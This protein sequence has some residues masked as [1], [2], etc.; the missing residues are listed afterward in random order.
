M[1]RTRRYSP[2]HWLSM[3]L[4]AA[5]MCLV[6]TGTSL[7]MGVSGVGGRVGFTDPDAVDPTVTFGLHAELEQPGSRLHVVPNVHFW[8]S[9]G[10]SNVNPNLD[11]YYHFERDNMMSPYLGAG[12]GLNVLNGDNDSSTD[13][14]VNVLG[15]LSFPDAS[16]ARRYYIE[17][18]YTAS[19]VNQIALLTGI[20]FG[21]R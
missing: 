16:A 4:A 14:G 12:L 21:T 20:T 18:R 19:D 11:L 9:N 8:S 1:L 17:G 15:G 13:V 3:S 5:S 10:L 2:L 6:I 7:A